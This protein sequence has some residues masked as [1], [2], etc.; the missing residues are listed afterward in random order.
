MAAKRNRRRRAGTPASRGRGTPGWTFIAAGLLL[1]AGAVATAWY[2]RERLSTPDTAQTS[3]AAKPA[4]K[5]KSRAQ[6]STAPPPEKDYGFYDILPNAEVVVPDEAKEIR[7]NT[8][9]APL[10]VPGVYVLQAGSF[11][12]FAEADRVKARLALLGIASQIQQITVDGREHHR[13]R[14]G[15]IEQLAE[16]NRVRQ[17]LRNAKIDV[18]VI[19]V[20]E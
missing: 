18:L 11:A 19:R 12:S 17:R 8:T 13:V 10:E 5:P 15:P 4:P 20:G 1:G 14:I 3:D 2:V 7:P 9:P 6:P 16:V